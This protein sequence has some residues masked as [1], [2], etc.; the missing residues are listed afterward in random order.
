MKSDFKLLAILLGLWMLC[1]TTCTVA[2][3]HDTHVSDKPW[4]PPAYWVARDTFK[5]ANDVCW[6]VYKDAEPGT[7]TEIKLHVREVTCP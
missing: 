1:H 2:H 5:D 7:L 4:T 6:H 3:G